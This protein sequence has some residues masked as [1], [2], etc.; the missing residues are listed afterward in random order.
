M[1]H[2]QDTGSSRA[3]DDIGPEEPLFLL[4]TYQRRREQS[5]EKSPHSQE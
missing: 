2:E 4:G 3:E 1:Q 5:E